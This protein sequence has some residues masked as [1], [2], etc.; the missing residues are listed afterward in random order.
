MAVASSSASK[1]IASERKERI[2]KKKGEK[3]K[4]SNQQSGSVRSS[5]AKRTKSPGVRVIGGRIYDSQNGTT[6]H[7]CRQ[8]TMDF[9]AGCRNQKKKKSCPIKFCHKC[10]LN[11]YGEK[12]EE[13]SL[14]EDWKCPKCR[15]ICNCSLCMKKRGHQP[16]GIL[17]HTAKAT[18]FSSVSDM[19]DTKG[20][21]NFGLN[22]M[23]K[24]IG[25]SPK[26]LAASKKEA[27]VASPRKRGKENIFDGSGDLNFHPMPSALNPDEKKPKKMKLE[28]LKKLQDDNRDDGIL[29]KDTSPK[30]PQ[31]SARASKKEVKTNGKVDGV[32]RDKNSSDDNRDDR[33]LLK[34]TSPKKPQFSTRISKKGVK[35]NGKVDGVVRDKNNSDDNRDGGILL[36]ETSP[37]KP[38]I[39]TR[40]SKKEVKMNGKVDGVLRD[41][42]NSKKLLKE[43][44]SEHGTNQKRK[45]RDS[46]THK[47]VEV[48]DSRKIGNDEGKPKTVVKSCKVERNAMKYQSTDLDSEISL[49]QGIELTT[50]AGIDLQPE[51]IGHALQFLEFCAAF[52][53]ILDLKKGLPESVLKELRRGRSGQRGK[54]S[55]VF[56]FHIQLLS[57]IQKDL[58][59]KS[60]TLC[61]TNDKNSWVH[62]LKNCVSKS[63]FV[64]KELPLKCLD[65][66]TDGY[67]SLDFS[68]KLILL[69]CICDEVLSTAQV[70]SWIDDQNLKFAEKVKEAKE[71][72]LAAKDK[73]KHLKQKLLDEVAKTITAKN[74]A[75]LTISEHEAIS[76]QIKTEAAKAHAEMLESKGMVP[77]KK[78]RSDAVRT[79]PILL[80]INGC[81]YWRLKGYSD[82]SDIL[83]QDMGHWDEVPLVDKWFAFDV[84]Q[85]KTIE[86]DIFSLRERR[87]R[88]Q[89]VADRFPSKYSET[90]AT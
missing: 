29:L 23:A 59:E 87:L 38:Q 31:I 77:E 17:V 78:S 65:K 21:E 69:N 82:N 71:R 43:V 25:T 47:D 44:P 48:L 9:S 11:R 88:Y 89:K 85:K 37:K 66:G 49:P 6:C 33:I 46:S 57:F 84:E 75:P 45:E 80:G 70:R 74:G 54:Y 5:P 28:R 39:S 24:D 16:T 30:K 51:D 56:Q 90:N 67:D 15:G 4:K 83:L 73:E 3:G 61:P 26:K 27:E 62:A 63:E 53:E 13:M 40:I 1:Q 12:A 52:A 68:K 20:P 72:V 60:P 55:V 14:L 58:G 86:K 81:T 2:K 19:L 32:T 35:T 41:K 18:G 42:S 64:L 34:E 36:K 79:E 8:K 22:K 76:S 7:Q 50:V 10:L